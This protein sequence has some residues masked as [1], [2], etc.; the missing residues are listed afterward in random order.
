[1]KIQKK[2]PGRGRSD[3]NERDSFNKD[4]SVAEKISY[5]KVTIYGDMDGFIKAYLFGY[6]KN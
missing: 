6:S 3:V 1:M 4:Y 2:I 5:G